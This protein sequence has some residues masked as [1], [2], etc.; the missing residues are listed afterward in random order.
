MWQAHS[1]VRCSRSAAPCGKRTPRPRGL[2]LH[3]AQ[4]ATRVRAKYLAALEAEQFGQLPAEAYAKAFVRTYADYLGLDGSLYVAVL[5]ARFAASRPAP[6]PSPK[7]AVGLPSVDLRAAA[8][9]SV[10]ALVTAASM[11]AWRFDAGRVTASRGDCWLSVRAG[12]RDGRVLYEGMLRGAT[13]SAFARSASG[14]VWARPGT[15]R[16]C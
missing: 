9:V 5:G 11:L 7:R 16:R 13:R 4:R 15:W 6:P 2:E 10:A 1:R 8:L 14:F 12:S 3:D